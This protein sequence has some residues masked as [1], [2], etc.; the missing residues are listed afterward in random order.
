[1]TPIHQV[2]RQTE[3]LED[4]LVNN[5]R[6]ADVRR[7][8]WSTLS[9]G[10]L[11]QPFIEPLLTDD[12]R[13]LQ[14][15]DQA[16]RH[17][18]LPYEVQ[19]AWIEHLIQ[20]D[21]EPSALIQYIGSSNSHRLGRYFE[22]LWLYFFSWHAGGRI[23]NHNL[24]IS[25]PTG[26]T[27]GELDIILSNNNHPSSK[28]H[29]ELAVKFYLQCHSGLWL[30]PNAQDQLNLKVNHLIHHQLTLTDSKAYQQRWGIPADTRGI[31]LSGMLCRP[32]SHADQDHSIP[33]GAYWGTK[34]QWDDMLTIN[35]NLDSGI[36][37]VL[38]KEKM[39][40]LGPHLLSDIH[41]ESIQMWSDA[42]ECQRSEMLGFTLNTPLGDQCYPI[43]FCVPDQY[44][45]G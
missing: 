10:L 16:T 5:L 9:S 27:L 2:N 22:Q 34:A 4:L 1:M 20:L 7:L 30:G 6:H 8:A 13:H 19:S 35:K 32:L 36:K 40:W 44:P 11:N 29:L 39:C 18:W 43:G 3:A 45:N 25:T 23:I 15:L 33:I 24:Q 42:Q 37:L 41:P 31:I 14:A 26:K 38:L 28:V 21:K 17:T 12:E